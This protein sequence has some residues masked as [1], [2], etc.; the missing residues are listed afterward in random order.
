MASW[1]KNAFSHLADYDLGN[2]KRFHLY[3]WLPP[4]FQASMTGSVE[5]YIC[6]SKPPLKFWKY[7]FKV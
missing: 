3:Q 2:Q 7:F 5:S 6:F 1:H 4:I